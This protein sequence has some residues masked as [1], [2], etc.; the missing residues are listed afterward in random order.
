MKQKTKLSILLI[1]GAAIV[2][3]VCYCLN[4]SRDILD[5][6]VCILLLA[7][8]GIWKYNNIRHSR[9]LASVAYRLYK[10]LGGLLPESQLKNE[11]QVSLDKSDCHFHLAPKNGEFKISNVFKIV[12]ERSSACNDTIKSLI[13]KLQTAEP[14]W[15]DRIKLTWKPLPTQEYEGTLL[16]ECDKQLDESQLNQIAEFIRK[17]STTL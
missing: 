15:E 16:L 6:L 17:I 5:L 13:R 3:A 4:V 12:K 9:A 1:L 11:Y 8:V 10:M 2:L 14:Y 7:A